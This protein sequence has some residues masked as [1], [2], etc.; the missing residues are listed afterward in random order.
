MVICS[1]LTGATENKFSFAEATE[2]KPGTT[3]V[4]VTVMIDQDKGRIS[5]VAPG[6]NVG[7]KYRVLIAAGSNRPAGIRLFSRN[8]YS[9]HIEHI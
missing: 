1:S 8:N 9:M 5:A 4:M 6:C 7:Y 2:N 3:A